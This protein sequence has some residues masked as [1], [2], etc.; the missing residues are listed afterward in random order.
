MDSIPYINNHAARQVILVIDDNAMNREILAEILADDYD[1]LQAENGAVGLSLMQEHFSRISVILLD[2]YMPVCNGFEFLEQK[3]ANHVFDTL[4]VIVMTASSSVEDEIRCLALGASDFVTKPY[5]PEVMINRIKS[6][7]RFRESSAMLDN[8]E[9]DRVTKLLSKEFFSYNAKKILAETD[10]AHYDVVCA[11]IQNFPLLNERYDRKIID[12]ILAYLSRRLQ[13]LIPG[14][15]IGGRIAPD[16]LAFL[17][18]HKEKGWEQILSGAVDAGAPIPFGVKY[19][20][21]EDIDRGMSVSTLCERTLVALH[22]ARERYDVS[23]LWYDEAL[24]RSLLQ[25]Q[26]MIEGMETALKDRQFHVFFQPKHDLQ[27]DRIIG[28]E[29]LVRWIHPA[30][31]FISPGTFIPL[32]ERNG[33]LA[34]L[35]P[36]VW[37][38]CCREIVRCRDMGLPAV[39]VSINLSRTLFDIQDPVD[40]LI[41]LTDRYG[42]DHSLLHIELTESACEEQSTTIEEALKRFHDNGFFVE[43]DDFGAGYSN[44]TSLRTLALDAMKLDMSI[45]RHASR[46][47]DYSIIRYAILLAECM[48]LKTIAEGVET[49]EERD[50]LRILGCDCVQGYFYS[51]P[52]PRED[53]ETYLIRHGA[54][55]QPS[56]EIA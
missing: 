5:V 30:M 31:G 52:L 47:G 56:K 1:V 18:R 39:P 26:M 35:D 20:I 49:R 45:I 2:V 29:A 37:E 15:T 53:F 19:G 13:S 34:H 41:E 6:I 38:E 4:P 54:M 22:N 32:F 21:I 51:K 42:I 25:E 44:I 3:Q 24:R 40:Q 17:I 55:P 50:A 27:T 36:Y 12:D 10:P 9:K 8:L 46:T 23:I 11:N 33:F 14:I 48:K 28:A 16:V 7:I 43:L